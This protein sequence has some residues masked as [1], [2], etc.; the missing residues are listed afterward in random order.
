MLA[1]PFS[2]SFFAPLGFGWTDVTLNTSPSIH[3][4]SI[5]LSGSSTVI[6]GSARLGGTHRDGTKSSSITWS[7]AQVRLASPRRL[8][9][10]SPFTS[11]DG[12]DDDDDGDDGH[13]QQPANSHTPDHRLV[14]LTCPL[15]SKQ[16]AKV[17]SAPN[18]HGASYLFVL[19]PAVWFH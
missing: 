1:S 16:R 12:D 13:H 2:H 18:E 6:S 19:P 11:F 7:E 15:G 14:C 17:L 9:S 8:Q 10:S 5:F 3:G 4:R